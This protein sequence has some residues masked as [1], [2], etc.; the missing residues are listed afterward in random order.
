MF[1][2]WLLCCWDDWLIDCWLIV[3]IY[4]GV[5]NTTEAKT[6]IIHKASEN[7]MQG[8][9]LLDGSWIDVWS[10]LDPSQRPSWNQ[11][12]KEDM[13][14]QE[15][16]KKVLKP[17]PTMVPKGAQV[18]LVLAPKESAQDPLT[19]EYTSTKGKLWAL[20]LLPYRAQTLGR[21]YT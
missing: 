11:V 7:T 1:V 2:V 4:L 9:W 20:G 14:Y 15:D 3:F 12:S 19:Q 16:V 21:I 18:N 10:S 17:G 13:G 8:G 6:K 5:E